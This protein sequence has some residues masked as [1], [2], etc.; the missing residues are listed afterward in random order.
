MNVSHL[1]IF[2]PWFLSMAKWDMSL[3]QIEWGTE[4]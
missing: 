2:N 3:Q 4:L 1:A